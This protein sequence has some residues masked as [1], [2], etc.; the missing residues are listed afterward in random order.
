MGLFI[1]FVI[2]LV[3]C[4]IVCRKMYRKQLNIQPLKKTKA[5]FFSG[6]ISFV[7]F[8]VINTITVMIVIPDNTTSV[9]AK[10]FDSVT[11]KKFIDLYND[12][13]KS[14]EISKHS[15]LSAI[16][17]SNHE[18]QGAEVRFVTG[19]GARGRAEID[20]EG[21]IT[22]I[23]WT[24]ENIDSLSLLSMSSVVE[25]LDST[26][27]RSDVTEFLIHSLQGND[28]GNINMSTESKRVSYVLSKPAGEAL[29]L[30]LMPKF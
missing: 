11:A 17:I 27:V 3:L 19:H 30:H 8:I 24:V 2:S 10:T 12:D 22:S 9:A 21:R 4:I 25:V 7:L 6:F 15:D 13:L 26:M 16:K 1:G 20:N 29:T 23:Y 28:K 18:Q 5:V 14:I